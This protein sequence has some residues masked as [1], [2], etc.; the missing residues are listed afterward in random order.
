MC[1]KSNGACN[2]ALCLARDTVELVHEIALVLCVK[3]MRFCHYLDFSPHLNLI[4]LIK[5][6]GIDCVEMC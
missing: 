3:M 1:C 5:M 2:I 4:M 6:I